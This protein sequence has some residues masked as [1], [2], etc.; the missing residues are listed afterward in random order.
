MQ[1]MSL[2][3]LKE[4]QKWKRLDIPDDYWQPLDLQ[5]EQAW[6]TFFE[7]ATGC[8]M[9]HQCQARFSIQIYF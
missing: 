4:Q 7:C 3:A 1:T 5:E 6:G 8:M 9:E 2:A